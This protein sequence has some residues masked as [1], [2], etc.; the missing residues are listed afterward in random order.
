MNDM[1]IEKV[2][3]AVVSGITSRL[4]GVSVRTDEVMKNNGIKLHAVTIFDGKSNISPCI[5]LD[6]YVECIASNTM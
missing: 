6:T 4:D 3:E 5:Y 2:I 1:N